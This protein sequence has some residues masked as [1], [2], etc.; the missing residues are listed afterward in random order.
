M[1]TND[2]NAGLRGRER[3]HGRLVLQEHDGSFGYLQSDRRV[4]GQVDVSF[5]DGMLEE[6]ST[7]HRAEDATNHVVETRL[8]HPATIQRS[9]QRLLKVSRV[10]EG[11]PRL[12]VEP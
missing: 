6:A 4:R 12:L 8:G 11:P 10:V 2:R 9:H 1:T 5:G 7:K 3:Q